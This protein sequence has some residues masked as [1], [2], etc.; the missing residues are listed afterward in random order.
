MK[1]NDQS[2]PLDR[3]QYVHSDQIHQWLSQ[4]KLTDFA[5]SN[6][7]NQPVHPRPSGRCGETNVKIGRLTCVLHPLDI[8]SF[9]CLVPFPRIG[10][11]LSG[12]DALYIFLNSIYCTYDYL[13]VSFYCE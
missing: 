6:W 7:A 1:K 9:F 3:N 4:L 11:H 2:I 8:F 10:I 12:L 5:N 13:F